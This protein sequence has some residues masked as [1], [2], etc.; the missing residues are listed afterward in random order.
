MRATLSRVAVSLLLLLTSTSTVSGRQGPLL[1]PGGA[2][3]V[4]ETYL[5]AMRQ[6]AGI[7]GMSAVVLR[8]EQIVW[9]RGFGFQNVETR[10]RATPDTPY[11]VGD[12]TSTLSATLLLQCVEQRRLDL[13]VPFGRYPGLSQQPEPDATLRS[14]LSHAAPDG[15]SDFAYNLQRFDQLTGVMEWCAPQPFRKSIAHRILDRL[16]MIDSVPGVDLRDPQLVLPD[17]LFEPQDLDRYR[18]VLERM[19]V[20]YKVGSRRRPERTEIPAVA[21]TASN[22]LVSTVRDL[23]RFDTA[24]DSGLL[25]LPETLDIAWTPAAGRSGGRLPTGLGWFVQSYRGERVIWQ[26]GY[27]PNAYSSLLLKVPE[28]H[29]TFILLAN[30]D[31][32]S[33]PFHLEAGDV[34]RSLFATLFLRLVK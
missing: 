34:S 32:L 16:A 9:E 25:L 14:V 6:Q 33:A 21:L 27:I 13:D 1:P 2:F 11:L 7:P 31:G 26:F 15:A 4:L 30:S 17:G 12:I 3:S 23:A 18:Q 19:A 22:G 29:L 8:D 24:L 28:R 5:E 20:P 10:L